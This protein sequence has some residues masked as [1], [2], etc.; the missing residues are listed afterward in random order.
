[1]PD[2]IG[3]IKRR[4]EALEALV[5][6]RVSDFSDRKLFKAEVALREG[7]VAP[8]TIERWLK[9]KKYP[10]PDGYDHRGYPFW[11]LST[12]ERNDRARAELPTVIPKRP[13]K[14]KP[15]VKGERQQLADTS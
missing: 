6:G 13:S 15:P 14:D 7:D 4:L 8:R 9:E 12:L 3:D 2:I 1:M 5:R 10:Q 11:W